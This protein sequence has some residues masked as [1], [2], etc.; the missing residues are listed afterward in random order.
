MSNDKTSK[1]IFK[2]E[3]LRKLK[4]KELFD[5]FSVSIEKTF[6][7]LS[8]SRQG[9]SQQEA[10][11]RLR[12]YGPNSLPLAKPTPAW[13]RLLRQFHNPLIYVLWMS[14]LISLLLEHYV[15]CGVIVGVV[16]VNGIV[17]FIQEGKA[18]QAL[19]AILAMAKTQTIVVRE[20]E[21]VTIDSSELVPGDIVT[22]QAGDRVPADLRLIEEKELSCDESALTGE[23]LTVSKDIVELD[24]NCSLAEQKNMA[25][26]GT[27]VTSGTGLGVVTQTASQTQLGAIN[28]LVQSVSLASTPLQNQLSVFAKQLTIAIVAVALLTML[29]GMFIKGYGFSEMFQGAIGIAV[30]SI[31][32][33]LPA[34]VTITL[35][36][37]VQRMARHQALVRQLPA[38]EVLGSVDVICTDKT[39]TLTTNT[40]VARNVIFSGK[41]FRVSG[42]GYGP[43]GEL[44]DSI[45]EKSDKALKDSDSF[46]SLK[47]MAAQISFHCNDTTVVFQD[48]DWVINGDPTEGALYSLALKIGLNV[49]EEKSKPRLDE[50]PFESERRY[51]ATLHESLEG[52]TQGQIIFVKGAPDKLIN[53]CHQELS[54]AGPKAINKEYWEKELAAQAGNGM[55]VMALAYKNT[56]ANID[57]FDPQHIED[58]LILVA[59]VGIADPP[60]EDVVESIADCH[61]AGIRVKMI[62]GDNPMTAAAIGRELGLNAEIV[63]TGRELEALSISELQSTVDSV[64]IYARTS[65]ANKLQLIDALQK[66]GHVVAMT[67]DGVND[68]PAL[69]KANIGVAMGGKG[70]DAAKEAAHF[71]LTDDNFSTITRAIR[72]GRTVYDNILKAII[73]ILPTSFAEASIIVLA[74]VFGLVL[75]VTPAQI[76]WVNMVTGVTLSLAI[77]FE[78][79]EDNIMQRS[80]RS[81]KHSFITRSLLIRM[82]LVVIC[83][84]SIV[85]WMFSIYLQR[86]VSAEYARTMVVNALVLFEVV[87]LFNCRFLYQSSLSTRSFKRVLPTVLAVSAVMSLQLVFTYWPTSHAVFKLEPIIAKDWLYL[88]LFTLPLFFVVEIEKA[89]NKFMSGMVDKQSHADIQR[90]K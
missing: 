90:Q 79:G 42:D 66:N 64:D 57:G 10:K 15:D 40:M 58:G 4:P 34:I 35:A 53:Y 37:G 8:T 71:V 44:T 3:A 46:E 72:E 1:D 82:L 67:G 81:P 27:L 2:G 16:I 31:P 20:A 36:I 75:P 25:F 14:A 38:V 47:K 5:Y 41:S 45:L 83:M 23:S 86:G 61:S 48:E 26:M 55:R 29:F 22:L 18:E 21:L 43:D 6:A 70:T 39:G 85:F 19:L 73:Y 63:L 17:G 7:L 84:A 24:A 13:L 54:E 32:E 74:I 78:L 65:P 56:E 62:T 88:V 9:L 28:T 33:G 76:L 59:L 51:M 11:N 50:I 49:E 89:V 52:S 30:A 77:I 87:Y 60:R 69:K 80:P 68:A 12:E